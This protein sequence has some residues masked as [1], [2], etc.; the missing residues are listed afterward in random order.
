[1]CRYA[2]NCTLSSR[3]LNNRGFPLIILNNNY[4]TQHMTFHNYFGN[5]ISVMKNQNIP[6]SPTTTFLLNYCDSAAGKL[7]LS[8]AATHRTFP[9]HL[10]IKTYYCE[11]GSQQPFWLA[12]LSF[13]SHTSVLAHIP[14]NF[15]IYIPKHL[16]DNTVRTSTFF[17]QRSCPILA[18]PL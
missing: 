11:P 1:M 17:V 8:F 7:P 4:N 12:C 13:D 15:V 9:I 3:Q 6:V 5:R 2:Q 18:F 14:R 16:T 10:K